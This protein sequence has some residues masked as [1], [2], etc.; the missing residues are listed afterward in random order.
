[1]SLFFN[2]H[3][4]IPMDVPRNV[5]SP[6]LVGDNDSTTMTLPIDSGQY[7]P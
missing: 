5:S 6:A 3:N 4:L 7:K 1:M 2:H